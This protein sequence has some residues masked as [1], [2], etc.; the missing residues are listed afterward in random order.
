MIQ[1]R[2][3]E[4]MAIKA[5]KEGRRIT[6]LDITRATGIYNTTLTRLAND[7]AELIGKSTMN[8]LCAFFDCQPGDLFIYV[9]ASEAEAE[10]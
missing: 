7:K 4:L 10:R 3:R 2:L 5:R 8:R 6:Y 9:P 1:C